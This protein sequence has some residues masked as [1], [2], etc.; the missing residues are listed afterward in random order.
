[1]VRDR[2]IG[3]ISLGDYCREHRSPGSNGEK[4]SL[5]RLKEV[6]RCQIPRSRLGMFRPL[7]L[8]RK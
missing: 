5:K 1:M 3:V 8:K 2:D 6:D 4:R 7:Q